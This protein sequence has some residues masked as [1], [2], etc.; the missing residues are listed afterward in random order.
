VTA[1]RV[2]LRVIQSAAVPKLRE[3][4]LYRVAS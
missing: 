2:R 1:S 3:F 4:G